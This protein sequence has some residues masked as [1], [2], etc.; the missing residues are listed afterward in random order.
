MFIDLIK[1]V[2][3]DLIPSLFWSFLVE[4]VLGALSSSLIRG[5]SPKILMLPKMDSDFPFF[6]FF[7]FLSERERM[8]KRRSGYV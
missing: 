1:L 4:V 5:S 8:H 3:L 7:S 2:V 6:F